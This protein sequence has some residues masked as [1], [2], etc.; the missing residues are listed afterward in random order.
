MISRLGDDLVR[1]ARGH[2]FLSRNDFI[3]EFSHHHH[4]RFGA[5]QANMQRH[6]LLVEGRDETGNKIASLWIGLQW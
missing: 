1:E 4:Q 2:Y 5:K 6:S 3:A